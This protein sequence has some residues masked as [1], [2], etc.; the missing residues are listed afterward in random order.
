MFVS[1]VF[2]KH[3]GN[4][5]KAVALPGRRRAIRKDMAE[6]AVATGTAYFGASHTH[7]GVL[8]IADML[9]IEGLKEAR[10]AGSRIKLGVRAEQRQ[11]AQPAVV[12]P[13][14]FVVQQGPTER[15]LGA[16]VQQD[17]PLF[18]CQVGSFL[19]NLCFIQWCQVITCSGNSHSLP[20]QA[21][22]PASLSVN[23]GFRRSG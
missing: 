11:V 21:V 18:R 3:H 2:L 7:A 5:V 9:R 22:L 8:D 15:V 1:G 17:T 10:P 19:L 20:P 13:G 12:N 14:F 23:S 4:R 6:M 16:M